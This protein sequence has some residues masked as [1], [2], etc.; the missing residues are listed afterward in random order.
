MG[1]VKHYKRKDSGAKN[2]LKRKE[3]RERFSRI[4]SNSEKTMKIPRDKYFILPDGS[5]LTDLYDLAVCL[6]NI[7][8]QVL[9]H[10]VNEEKNDFANW[11]RDVFKK[12][13]LADALMQAKDKNELH[14]AVLKH[15][16]F[17]KR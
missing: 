12:E 6:E 16:A 10:H 5:Q 13:D 11:V 9:R 2:I 8:D 4:F 7:D 3:K 1:W 15:L 14:V 17:E